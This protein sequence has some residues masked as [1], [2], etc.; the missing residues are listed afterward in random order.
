LVELELAL[1]AR[2]AIRL[3]SLLRAAVAHELE[4][5]RSRGETADAILA[6]AG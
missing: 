3:G 1:C 2:R 6:T 4:I 5:T